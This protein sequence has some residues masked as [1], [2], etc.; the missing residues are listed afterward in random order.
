MRGELTGGGR[1]TKNVEQTGESQGDVVSSQ[2][3]KKKE[4]VTLPNSYHRRTAQ[5]RRQQ[6]KNFL[7][8]RREEKK[9][10]RGEL[11]LVEAAAQRRAVPIPELPVISFTAVRGERK[12][13][14]RKRNV[15]GG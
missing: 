2:Q 7:S 13:R 12:G 14:K 5:K 11:T 10:K 8:E 15:G 3:I 1:G 9:G 4:S 6:E